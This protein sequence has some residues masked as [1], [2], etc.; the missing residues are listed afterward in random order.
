MK[1]KSIETLLDMFFNKR[2][3]FW[4]EVINLTNQQELG[5]ACMKR[6]CDL[7]ASEVS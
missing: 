4:I 2:L 7:Y 1:D 3:L 6:L 5:L